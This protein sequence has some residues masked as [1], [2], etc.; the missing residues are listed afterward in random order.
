MPRHKRASGSPLNFRVFA[1]RTSNGQTPIVTGLHHENRVLA[2]VWRTSGNPVRRRIAAEWRVAAEV[3]WT[4]NA[5]PVGPTPI[6]PSSELGANRR[7]QRR[8]FSRL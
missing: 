7:E 3:H 8:I 4:A 5:S 6:D 1:K 2:S